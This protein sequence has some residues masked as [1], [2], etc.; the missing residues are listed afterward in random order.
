MEKSALALHFLPPSHI[1]YKCLKKKSIVRLTCQRSLEI[2]KI[3]GKVCFCSNLRPLFEY[4]IFSINSTLH[5]S[6]ITLQ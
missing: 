3:Q 4:H 1:H 2:R 5:P 6:H